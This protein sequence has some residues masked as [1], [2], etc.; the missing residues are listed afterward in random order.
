MLLLIAILVCSMVVTTIGVAS[1]IS[2]AQNIERLKNSEW[3]EIGKGNL[4]AEEIHGKWVLYSSPAVYLDMLGMTG[5][6]FKNLSTD[7]Y[8]LEGDITTA[9]NL[10]KKEAASIIT[11]KIQSNVELLKSG[12]YE[13][14]SSSTTQHRLSNGYIV[15]DDP[16]TNKNISIIGADGV[17]QGVVNTDEYNVIV[18]AVNQLNESNEFKGELIWAKLADVLDDDTIVYYSN[19]HSAISNYFPLS[20]YTVSATDNSEKLIMDASHYGEGIKFVGATNNRIVGH[21]SRKGVLLVYSKPNGELVEIPFTGYPDSLSPDG[22]TV[23]FRNT[24]DNIINPQ[25]HV[26]DLNNGSIK[27]IGMPSGYFYNMNGAWSKDGTKFA[28]YMNGFDDNEQNK[29]YRTNVKIGIVDVEIGSI[30]T[31]EKPSGKSNLYTLGSVSWI[32]NDYIIAYTDDNTSWKLK[33]D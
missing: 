23:L 15:I 20:L 17:D 5:K 25:F 24:T 32:G 19:K 8:E 14:N 33:V 6:T 31:Y 3:T 9:F 13:F 29:S 26:L 11:P 7:V 2:K 16:I 4:R 1:H 10:K 30:V 12:E 22:N 28:F 21:L 27:A 18:D